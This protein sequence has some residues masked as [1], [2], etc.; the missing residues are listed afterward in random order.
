MQ[1]FMVAFA[2][3]MMNFVLALC[4]FFIMF[5]V[6]GVADEQST[7]VSEVSAGSPAYG[8]IMP[9]DKILSINGVDIS[10]WSLDGTSVRSELALY[11]GNSAFTMVVERDGV[12][13]TLDPIH[14]Q[15]YFMSFNFASLPGSEALV[16]SMPNQAE[17]LDPNTYEPLMT[18]DVI[19][20][21]DGHT[22]ADWDELI[23]F[24]KNYVAGSSKDNPTVIVYERGGELRSYSFVAYSLEVLS[25]QGYELFSSR[26]GIVGS[27]HFSFLGSVEG[28]FASF[29]NASGSIFKTLGL[30]FGSKQVGVGDLSGF[31]GMYTI[32]SVAASNGFISLLNWIG[33]LSVNLGILNL[34]PIP[35]LDGG[36][37]VF[38][39]YEAITKKKPNQKF[40]NLLHTIVFFLLIALLVYVSYNDILR[41][42]R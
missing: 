6:G 25:T 13:V 7:F 1:R 22:F 42:F 33:F 39:G 15:Y 31:I 16:V 21:I 29:T 30:L 41:L 40:E 37:I 2:G 34:L 24:Q 5:L 3:P 28:M 9:G 11:S 8:I 26:I 12:Q 35:A 38:L 36:R 14:P 10:S 20:S 32:T 27:S 23:L 4:V 18:N 19:I 17:G